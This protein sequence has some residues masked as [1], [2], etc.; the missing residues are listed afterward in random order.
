MAHK[1]DQ[2]FTGFGLLSL[3]KGQAEEG[4]FILV[5]SRDGSLTAA[6]YASER[7]AIEAAVESLEE[8]QDESE[9]RATLEDRYRRVQTYIADEGGILEIIPSPIYG[10]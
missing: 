1:E 6:A 9:E 3:S 7:G 4:V 5:V 2:P 10:A 8:E